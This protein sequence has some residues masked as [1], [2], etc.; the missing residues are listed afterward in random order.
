MAVSFDDFLINDEPQWI[1]LGEEFDG[2]AIQATPFN[3]AY[4][5]ARAARMRAAA[6][7]YAGD[8]NKIPAEKTREIIVDCLRDH[9]VKDVRGL[10]KKRNGQAVSF[11]EFIDVLRSPR[12]ATFL[13]AVIQAVSAAGK[14]QAAADEEAAGN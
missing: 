3:D 8:E 2:A 4:A 13:A 9:V 5:N 6:R 14:A 10:P 12:G 7:N 1:S 11:D